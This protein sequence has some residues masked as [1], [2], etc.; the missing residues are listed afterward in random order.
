MSAWDTIHGYGKDSIIRKPTDE[1]ADRTKK[2]K[3]SLGLTYDSS[4]A[5]HRSKRRKRGAKIY[6][7]LTSKRSVR[8]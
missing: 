2:I 7:R 1:L 8:T 5:K 4:T 6:A 3:N